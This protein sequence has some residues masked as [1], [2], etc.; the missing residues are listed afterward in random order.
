MT[1]GKT[2]GQTLT[3]CL[4]GDG[5]DGEVGVPGQVPRLDHVL[6]DAAC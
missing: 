5:V 4:D 6:A 2:V 1:D 3:F